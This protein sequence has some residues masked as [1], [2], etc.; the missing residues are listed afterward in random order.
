MKT[1]AESAFAE[2][3]AARGNTLPGGAI[4]LPA[5]MA[6]FA[7]FERQGLPHRRVEAWKYTDLR[8]AL[9][10][11][12]TPTVGD[13]TIVSLKDLEMA[14]GAL[15]QLDA[16]RIVLV[17]GGYRAALSSPLKSSTFDVAPLSSDWAR[18]GNAASDL[19]RYAAFRD[20][21]VVAL[22]AAFVTDGALVRVAADTTHE[23]PLLIVHLTAGK[24]P[25]FASTRNIVEC[26][27]G[28]KAT[29]IEVFASVGASRGHA[30]S[31]TELIA[32][33]GAEI[34]HHKVSVT[35][36]ATHIATSVVQL[37]A[38]VNYR[39]FQLTSTATLARNQIFLTF[40]G[41]GSKIDVSGLM[42]GRGR[43]HIDT[44]LV[45]DHAVPGCLSRELFKT[46]LDDHARSVFQ[47]KVIVRPG[48]QKT[49]GKQMANALML[50]ENAEFDSKPELEI[51]ADDVV[52]GHGATCAELSSELLFYMRSRGIPLDQARAL[53]VESF[54]GEALDRI[55][56][57]AIRAA[58][59]E[60]TSAWLN[61]LNQP[62]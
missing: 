27:A 7:A 42:L 32:G 52:C 62:A 4:L 61:A 11:P 2:Q 26:G 40:A 54:A 19:T 6:A 55:E 14:L 41:E 15:A 17:N 31:V 24:E 56:D 5:R 16:D 37:G 49:D 44:T 43:D 9:K 38:R 29:I 48:A 8:A 25:K 45:I 53:L 50:S 30:N 23:R 59:G 1:K 10:E 28:S 13:D 39:A 46:V 22:N 20:E 21:S 35:A 12:I 60:I 36:C 58:L 34:A 3:F 51:Y 57:E 47:G 33:D 18:L